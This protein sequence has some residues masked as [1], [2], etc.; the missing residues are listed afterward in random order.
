[1]ALTQRTAGTNTTTSLSAFIVGVDD[2]FPTALNPSGAGSALDVAY[3]AAMNNA[4]KN[5]PVAKGVYGLSAASPYTTDVGSQ[6]LPYGQAYM[7]G[8][9][10]FIPKR[11]I[12]Q[13]KMGDVILWD[14][15]TGWPF[16]LSADAIENGP[17]TYVA[18]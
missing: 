2:S 15:T 7:R 6:R 5:D 8:G 3:V 18:T 16:V 4:I 12:L 1:M 9:Q 10:L 11:G 17:Y 14:T 13:L